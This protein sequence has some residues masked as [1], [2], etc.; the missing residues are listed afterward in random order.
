MMSDELSMR[1]DST[2]EPTPLDPRLTELMKSGMEDTPAPLPGFDTQPMVDTSVI[3]PWEPRTEIDDG[4]TPLPGF[5]PSHIGEMVPGTVF[6]IPV[7]AGSTAGSGTTVI[8]LSYASEFAVQ[9]LPAPKQTCSGDYV[10]FTAKNGSLKVIVCNGYINGK[11]NIVRP[12]QD[13][14]PQTPVTYENVALS[15][16]FKY[17]G[18]FTHW[19]ADGL[20]GVTTYSV[21]G[22]LDGKDFSNQ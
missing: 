12:L 1:G 9:Q 21:A 17:E 15:K 4:P 20:A 8:T 10:T 7:V 5:D 3:T 22:R 19:R 2:G 13:L 14:D 18:S 16:P 11:E 6:P